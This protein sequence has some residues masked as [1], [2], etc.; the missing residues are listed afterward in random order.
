MTYQLI[1]CGINGCSRMH[2]VRTSREAALTP[3]VASPIAAS[4]SGTPVP[5][6]TA[7]ALPSVHRGG[8]R[9]ALIR[10][11]GSSGT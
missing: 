9:G 5:S 1:P 10:S 8:R 6:E 3:G 4:A 11:A 7:R 2:G